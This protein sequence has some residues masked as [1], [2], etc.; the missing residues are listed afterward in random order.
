MLCSAGSTTGEPQVVPG[1]I[2][3]VYDS[4]DLAEVVSRLKSATGKASGN[5]DDS[6]H[7]LEG[8][9]FAWRETGGGDEE[10]KDT[11]EVVCPYGTWVG[12]ELVGHRFLP[13]AT[14]LQRTP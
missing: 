11:V 5:G 10:E 4:P 13:T 9:K 14:R 6:H 8:T 1:T 12:E 7:A 2:G 3:L